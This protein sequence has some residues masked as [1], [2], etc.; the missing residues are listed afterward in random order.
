MADYGSDI[1]DELI[2]S[3]GEELE[4]P[5]LAGEIDAALN[6]EVD[7]EIIDA[8]EESGDEDV[9]DEF[10]DVEDDPGIIDLSEKK[11]VEPECNI[12]DTAPGETTI[13]DIG[14]TKRDMIQFREMQNARDSRMPDILTRFEL[15]SLIISRACSLMANN[16]PLVPFDVFDPVKIAERELIQGKSLRAVMRNDTRW[17]VSDFKYFP[18]GFM[19]ESETAD[20]LHEL[21]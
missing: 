8:P 19:D 9:E 1:D 3:L 7:C 21:R 18:R 15:A 4:D 12:V 10:A 6:A 11:S 17:R 5:E 16:P 20:S 13:S 2:E 14:C